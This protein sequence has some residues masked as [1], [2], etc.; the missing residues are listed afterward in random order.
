[1]TPK[2]LDQIRLGWEDH[3]SALWWLVLIY[4]RPFEF[5]SEVE[6]LSRLVRLETALRLCLHALIPMLGLCILSRLLVFPITKTFL[7]A[8]NILLH[9]IE[10]TVGIAV[11][12]LV[13][14]AIGNAFGV[15]AGITSGITVGIAFYIIGGITFGIAFEITGGI[16]CGIALG[17]AFGVGFGIALGIA[18]VIAR[19][20]AVGIVLGFL[21]GSIVGI[22]VGITGEIAIG[23]AIGITGIVTIGMA[24]A[25]AFGLISENVGGIVLGIAFGIACG[26]SV[27]ISIGITS[28][29]AMGSAFVITVALI[30]RVFLL[31]IYYHPLFWWL[32]WPKPFSHLYRFHPVAWDDLCRIAF[33]GLDRLLVA[34]T[35]LFPEKGIKEIERLIYSYPSQRR[36]AL[37]AELPARTIWI[38]RQ[39]TTLDNLTE[40]EKAVAQLPEGK[41]GFLNQTSRLRAMVA[42]I[43]KQQTRFETVNRPV[44]REPLAQALCK[45]IENFQY[46]IA[47]FHEPLAT[48]FRRASTHWLA[49]AQ[50]Q[51]QQTQTILQKEP[52]PQL[53][54]AGDPVNREQEAFVPRY[55][56]VGDLEQQIMLA[57]GCPGVVL[58]GRRR[59]GKSTVLGNLSGFLPSTVVPVT[60]S[61]QDP[62][63]FTSLA[64]WMKHLVQKLSATLAMPSSAPNEMNDLPGLMRM[65]GT[66]N[67]HLQEAGKRVLL[68][69]DE[70]EN[71]DR[72]LGEKVFP[73][74]LL[75]TIR[76]SI[77]THRNITWIFSGSHEITELKH[78]EWPSY[79]VS[80]RTIEVPLFTMAETRL[81]LTEPLKFS[82]LFK[83]ESKRPRFEPGF[84]G[85]NG[86]ER[87]QREAGGWPHLVQL[88]AETIVD[89]I[90]DEDKRQV[91]DELFER[92]LNKAIV[93]GHNVLYQL[94]RGESTL[95]GEWD[96]LSSFRTRE[97]QPLPGEEALYVSLRRRLLM[98]EASG[99]WRL[100]VPLMARWLKMR[101]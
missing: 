68:A 54:R 32:T 33:P 100:R 78:A 52:A 55:S 80:A 3:K 59:M 24:S 48:E 76:E 12:I 50:A 92:A 28:G 70:Y 82:P 16:S 4:R 45:E 85:E 66:Y 17:I 9:L 72:K 34:Y 69:I 49:L 86:I 44:L 22:T 25:I 29:I 57:T 53:F 75:A 90:N 79:L 13:G 36:A 40:L 43:T 51:W 42:E 19:G 95:P 94:L 61:M 91:D 10:I 5:R 39:T 26:I 20:V 67:A 18:L 101:G 96:Y 81:L 31:R 87:I 11:G 14:I 88:I 30:S 60:I 98:E 21:L 64:D 89:V 15:T 1:M 47:G 2:P 6:R 62:Q 38:A 35:D 7:I 83:D 93:S 97:T 56:V 27:G 23:N 71:I 41:E 65:L 63:A 84:W 77:Q 58:Y 73:E 8:D 46:R 74:D 99:E 37:R